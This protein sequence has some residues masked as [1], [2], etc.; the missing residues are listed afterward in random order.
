MNVLLLSGESQKSRDWTED[1]AREINGLYIATYVHQYRHWHTE[2]AVFDMD[3][4]LETLQATHEVLGKK[5][6]VVFAK[7]IGTLVL[8]RALDAKILQPGAVVLAGLP[9]VALDHH[10]YPDLGQ[11]YRDAGIHVSLIQNEHDPLGGSAAVEAYLQPF[12][13]PDHFVEAPGNTHDYLDYTLI[14]QE[15]TRARQIATGQ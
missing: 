14:S 13:M 9:L 3:H 1:V 12:G 15:L 11:S 7:S 8:G 5:D 4:E 2:S 6:Y 10:Q